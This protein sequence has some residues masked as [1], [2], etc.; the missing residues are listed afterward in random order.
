[1]NEQNSW[2]KGLK[3]TMTE[4]DECKEL[5]RWVGLATPY[6]TDGPAIESRWG[7]DF[8]HLS[9]TS[10]EPTQPPI[11]WVPGLLGSKAA[12]AWIWPPTSI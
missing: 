8:P 6:G 3:E 4:V 10:V 9:I 2:N 1:M 5:E 12:G 7:R 11:K